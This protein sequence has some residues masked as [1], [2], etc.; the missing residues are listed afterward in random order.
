MNLML[1]SSTSNS[2]VRVTSTLQQQPL[3]STTLWLWTTL[4]C[5]VGLGYSLLASH[6][7]SSLRKGFTSASRV[8][9]CPVLESEGL[10]D[11]SLMTATM[12]LSCT[13]S[14]WQ[15]FS[16]CSGDRLG[17]ICPSSTPSV[18]RTAR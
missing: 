5:T 8:R 13:C 6:S 16:L 14:T 3:E 17:L 1:C 4:A 9:Q 18:L 10:L 2:L 15:M 11:V 7:S 12:L